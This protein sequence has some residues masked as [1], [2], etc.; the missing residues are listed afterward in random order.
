M[1]V[2]TASAVSSLCRLKTY[3]RSTMTQEHLSDLAVLYIEREM[4]GQLLNPNVLDD[5]VIKFAEQHKNSRG[6]LI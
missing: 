6:T 4:S 3:L 5:L 2:S 1:G